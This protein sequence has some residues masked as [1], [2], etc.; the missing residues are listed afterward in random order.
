MQYATYVINDI[1][2]FIP[3]MIMISQPEFKV[4]EEAFNRGVIN[5]RPFVLE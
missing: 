1:V 4:V 3:T 5:R 2:T